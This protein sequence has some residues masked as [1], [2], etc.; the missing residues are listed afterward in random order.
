[1]HLLPVNLKTAAGHAAGDKGL[2][3]SGVPGRPDGSLN[4]LI[5]ELSVEEGS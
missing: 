4:G 5:D 2:L 1:M 3:A